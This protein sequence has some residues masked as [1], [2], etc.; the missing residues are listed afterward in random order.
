[1]NI[2][3]LQGSGPWPFD[4]T[5]REYPVPNGVFLDLAIIGPEG[6]PVFLD[7]LVWGGP[8]WGF[9]ITDDN[10]NMLC[11]YWS[12]QEPSTGKPIPLEG[13]Q[14]WQGTVIFGRYTESINEI[15]LGINLDPRCVAHLPTHLKLNVDNNIPMGRIEGSSFYAD[16]TDSPF[17]KV[18]DVEYPTPPDGILTIRG[19]GYITSAIR[20]GKLVLRRADALLDTEARWRIFQQVGETLQGVSSIAGVIPDENGN[21]NIVLIGGTSRVILE[22]PPESLEPEEYVD[23][24][25]VDTGYIGTYVYDKK[26]PIGV[27]LKGIDFEKCTVADLDEYL[28]CRTEMG[29][30]TP[31]PLD[32]VRCPGL[33]V[34]VCSL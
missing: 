4:Y 5:D 17:I 15:D 32:Y 21:V 24:G 3:Q 13:I 18:N 6:T 25:Y 8:T 34:V 7:S 2:S 16:L 23:T 29:I 30:P 1:M 33:G 12:N 10:R 22:T 9:C 28:K 11:W 31:L 14:G 26:I 19:T 20:E 27:V